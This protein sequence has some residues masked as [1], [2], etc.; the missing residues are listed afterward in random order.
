MGLPIRPTVD[1]D[2]PDLGKLYYGKVA[3]GNVSM[4]TMMIYRPSHYPSLFIA[5]E[6][7]GAYSFGA[8][9]AP[10]YVQ[11]KLSIPLGDAK[12]VADLITSQLMKPTIKFGR[13]L[14]DCCQK[15]TQNGN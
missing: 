7:K 14:P 4:F 10:G 5:I 3:L 11:E 12:N 13:Y 6:G 9:V 1:G 8:P 2:W 15:E